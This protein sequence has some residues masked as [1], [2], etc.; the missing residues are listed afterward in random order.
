MC[1]Q[2]DSHFNV[3]RFINF[4]VNPSGLLPD[5]HPLINPPVFQ[6]AFFIFHFQTTLV[7]TMI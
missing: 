3:D 7:C 6:I 2:L 4:L 1:F 5:F